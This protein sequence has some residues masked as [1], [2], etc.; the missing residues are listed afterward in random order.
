MNDLLAL[1]KPYLVVLALY[2]LG[3][4]SDLESVAV[5]AFGMFPGLFTWKTFPEFPDKDVVR[6]HLSD[7]KKSKFGALVKDRDLRGEGGRSEGRTKRY[8]L[9]ASG[10]EKAKELSKHLEGKTAV[11]EKTS[12]QYKRV[13]AP[14][15]ESRGFLRFERGEKIQEI[16]REQFLESFKLFG[17]DSAFVINGRLARTEKLI[18]GLVAEEQRAVIQKYISAGRSAFEL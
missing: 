2:E 8:A 9:T 18:E 15:L 14:V 16:G 4:E 6:V 7:A 11:A 5:K 10:V 13:V 3:G 17:D 1:P 12:L